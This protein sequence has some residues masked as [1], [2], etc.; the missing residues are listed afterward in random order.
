MVLVYNPS[1]LEAEVGELLAWCQLQLR[2]ETLTKEEKIQ[3]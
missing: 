2:K 3:R 1:A